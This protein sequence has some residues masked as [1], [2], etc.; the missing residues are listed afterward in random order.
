MKFKGC[1]GGN[2]IIERTIA[3]IEETGNTL[4]DTMEQAGQVVEAASLRWPAITER[5]GWDCSPFYDDCHKRWRLL[6]T[7]LSPAGTPREDE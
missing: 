2:M 4:V 7:C 5:Y 6:I 1:Q 3:E